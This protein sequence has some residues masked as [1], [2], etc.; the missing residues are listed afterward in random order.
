[1]TPD[2]RTEA[3]AMLQDEQRA[4]DHYHRF[5]LCADCAEQVLATQL[6]RVAALHAENDR[7]QNAFVDVNLKAE[8]AERER[9]EANEACRAATKRIVE[10]EIRAAALAEAAQAVVDTVHE[11]RGGQTSMALRAKLAEL[12][13]ALAGEGS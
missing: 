1:M 9:D 4:T 5:T 11:G 10:L 12:R 8:A 6:E 2:A 13:R 7:L 3:R